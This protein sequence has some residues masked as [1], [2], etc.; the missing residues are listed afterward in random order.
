MKDIITAFI[1]W[2]ILVFLFYG[3]DKL[4]A[5]KGKGRISEIALISASFVFA[6]L[7]SLLGMVVFNHKTGKLHFRILIPLAFLL[8][9]LVF[10][11]PEIR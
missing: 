2:N 7:G 5:K 11:L 9:L 3:I 1:L 6:A 8:N 4:C 10:L